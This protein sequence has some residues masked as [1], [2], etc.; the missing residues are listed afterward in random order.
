MAEFGRVDVL[1]NNAGGQ[2]LSPAEAITPKGFRTVI[3]LNV[4]AKNRFLKLYA[5]VE[6]HLVSEAD[7]LMEHGSAIERNFPSVLPTTSCSV[8]P[9]RPAATS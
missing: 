2:V 8:D 1:V 7:K 4:A 5:T 6:D 3:E 9:M